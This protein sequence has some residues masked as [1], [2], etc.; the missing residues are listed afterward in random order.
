MATSKAFIVL[1]ATS[2]STTIKRE[3]LLR[4]YGKNCYANPS[5][6]KGRKTSILLQYL[7][8]LTLN[9]SDFSEENSTVKIK[10]ILKGKHILKIT[11][12]LP[13]KSPIL[14]PVS[15]HYFQF[16]AHWIQTFYSHPTFLFTFQTSILHLNT[17]ILLMCVCP[18]I[19]AYA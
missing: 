1:W 6:C 19:V 17:F 10:N 13:F 4:F 9:L 18:C 12:F 3:E 7:C 14:P 5:Q 11:P 2:T 16:S 15:H 8:P